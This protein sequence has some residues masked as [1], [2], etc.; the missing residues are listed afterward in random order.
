MGQPQCGPPSEARQGPQRPPDDLLG[1]KPV[2]IRRP[3]GPHQS[4]ADRAR[5]A[6][7]A[8]KSDSQSADDWTQK[9]GE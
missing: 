5:P 6:Q 9:H 7:G 2:H 8:I 1:T 4:P 3:S